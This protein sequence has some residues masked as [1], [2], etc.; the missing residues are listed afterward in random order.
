MLKMVALQLAAALAI[1][2]L[3]ALLVGAHTGYSALVGGLISVLP[4]YYL[5]GRL[6]RRQGAATAT[7]SLRAIYLGEFIK[8]AFTVALFVIAIRLLSIDFLTVVLTY[9]AM[10]IVNGF[11]LLVADIGERPR[12]SASVPQ[13]GS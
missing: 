7:Q 2:A 10:M 8:I 5:V 9:L 12:A 6:T 13:A 3:C 4:N 11:A 1:A